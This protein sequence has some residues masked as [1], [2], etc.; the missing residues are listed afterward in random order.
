MVTWPAALT[1]GVGLFWG[2]LGWGGEGARG[3]GRGR[4]A[5][6]GEAT[7][8]PDHQC[9]G[10][11]EVHAWGPPP[12]SKKAGLIPTI[13]EGRWLP[14]TW[15][16]PEEE[17]VAGSRGP[18]GEGRAQ[19][20]DW[21]ACGVAGPPGPPCSLLPPAGSSQ[22]ACSRS[23]LAFCSLEGPWGHSPTRHEDIKKPAR[24]QPGK[25]PAS[26]SGNGLGPWLS[27]GDPGQQA[28]WAGKA[29][30]AAYLTQ[31]L[32]G[33]CSK[34]EF[35]DHLTGEPGTVGESTEGRAGLSWGSPFQSP[36]RRR[37]S[38]THVSQLG[39]NRLGRTVDRTNTRRD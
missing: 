7:Q 20:L 31:A 37:V 3:T 14:S 22:D 15:G 19:G 13:W 25:R 8:G 9:L 33:F 6:D 35:E 38:A 27:K 34:L 39:R 21:G 2:A 10:G 36:P 4:E 12:E 16:A 18:W 26:D 32:R 30:G 28:S 1:Q 23:V 24:E 11:F 5:A 17:P 29:E